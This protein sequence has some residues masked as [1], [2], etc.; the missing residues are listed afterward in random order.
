M[1]ILENNWVEILLAFMT[2][3]K[4]IF[5]YIPSE[6]AVKIFG[7]VDDFINYLVKDKRKDG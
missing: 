5:N 6:K 2:F 7:F 3:L 4:V 1:E